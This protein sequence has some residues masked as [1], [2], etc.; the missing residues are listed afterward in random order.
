MLQIPCGMA[1]NWTDLRLLARLR[2]LVD[3]P[4]LRKTLLEQ[5]R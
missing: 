3:S 4:V 1:G 5:P 2:A